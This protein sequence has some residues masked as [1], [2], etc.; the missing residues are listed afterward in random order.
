MI[1]RKLKKRTLK[2]DPAIVIAAFGSRKKGKVV[3]E[4][5][6]SVV[7]AHLPQYKISWAY[8]SEII[9]EK[10]AHPGVLEALSSLEALGYRRAVV[11]PIH[12]FPGTE[13]SVLSDMC[14]AFPGMRLAM[15]ETLLH[16]WSFVKEVLTIVS[17]DF[18]PPK[19]GYNI[20]VLHGTPLCADPANAIY[21]GLNNILT[22]NYENVFLSTLDGIPD[23]ETLFHNIALV[24]GH[25]KKHARIIPFMYAAGLHV[26]EDLI[27]SGNSYKSRLED[28]GFSVDWQ[29]VKYKGQEY[30]K[31]L[32]FYEEISILFVNRISRALGLLKFY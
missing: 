1:E 31:G 11:Q 13:Y 22:T 17:K 2:E 15:G 19:D 28:M 5:C 10:T 14:H 12:I 6:D 24:S 23:S 3:Y 30:P 9:R 8:T 20:V 21:L 18:I 25:T 29:T 16:R 32:G 4:L 26:E 27:G 7:K